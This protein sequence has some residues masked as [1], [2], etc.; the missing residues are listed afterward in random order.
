[1]AGKALGLPYVDVEGFSMH[2]HRGFDI[3][4]Y[5]L[6]G[7]DG[8]RHRDSLGNQNRIYRGGCLQWMRTG[9]GVLHEEFWETRPDRRTN[10]ELFQLWINLPASQKFDEPVVH[11]IGTS[12][13]YPWKETIATDNDGVRVRDIGATLDASLLCDESNGNNKAVANSRPPVTIRHVTM[14]PDTEWTATAPA[15]QSALVY[16]REG[17]ASFEASGTGS[18]SN[19]A[20]SLQMAT[21]RADGDTFFI[22]NVDKR[23]P[24][25]FL[26]LTGEPLRE[27]VAFGG[28]IVMNTQ[29]ELND[30][31]R[32]L[33]NGTFLRRDIALREH[34]KTVKLRRATSSWVV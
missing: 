15:D 14:D 31:F 32:Q 12:T 6:D 27:P 16:V 19:F 34:E 24:L 18:R 7:S 4:T 30:A 10:I 13:D 8:F 25:D 5:V 21:F 9:S 26:L 1:M 3:L 29:E 33:S 22:R 11:Y 28:P 23:R 20:K 17:T 2:P